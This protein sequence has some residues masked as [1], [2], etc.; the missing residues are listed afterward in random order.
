M[1][2]G[3]RVTAS[4]DA[5]GLARRGAPV[6]PHNPDLN[7]PILNRMPNRAIPQALWRQ[8]NP[9]LPTGIGRSD[10]AN[11]ASSRPSGRIQKQTSRPF[12]QASSVSIWSPTAGAGA[13]AAW[14]ARAAAGAV[15]ESSASL[16]SILS[17]YGLSSSPSMMTNF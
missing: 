10:S 13:A 15:A 1:T 17:R 9:A 8:H 2:V 14:A 12:L 7:H 16:G 3:S 5:F 4:S 11:Q 6:P